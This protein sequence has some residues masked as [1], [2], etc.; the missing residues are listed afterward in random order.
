[1]PTPGGAPAGDAGGAP[2]RWRLS[3]LPS[4]AGPYKWKTRVAQVDAAEEARRA[5]VAP[6]LKQ[7]KRIEVLAALPPALK[8]RPQMATFAEVA[9]RSLEKAP[10]DKPG[11]ADAGDGPS[12]AAETATRSA[13]IMRDMGG[14]RQPTVTPPLRPAS[15]QLV[16]CYRKSKHPMQGAVE[17]RLTAFWERALRCPRSSRCFWLSP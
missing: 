2:R 4:S 1:M 5:R 7:L 9:K 6:V 16:E 17:P 14:P 12:P 8:R 10:G 15:P 13:L 3:I 11:G